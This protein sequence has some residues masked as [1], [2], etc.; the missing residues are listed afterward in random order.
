MNKYLNDVVKFISINNQEQLAIL[1][2]NYNHQQLINLERKFSDIAFIPLAVNKILP[3]DVES[4]VNYFQK[5]STNNKTNQ[6]LEIYRAECFSNWHKDVNTKPINLRDIFP[7]LYEQVFDLLPYSE[8][9]YIRFQAYR[10]PVKLHKDFDWGYNLPL[11]QRSIIF[12]SNTDPTLFVSR[13]QDSQVEYIS[14]PVDTNSFLINN[15]TC[16]NGADYKNKLLI[17][18][19]VKGI[20]NIKKLAGLLTSSSA[21]Y[22]SYSMQNQNKRYTVYNVTEKKQVNQT[23]PSLEDVLDLYK[24]LLTAPEVTAVEEHYTNDKLKSELRVIFWNKQSYENFSIRVKENYENI[25][26]KL[27][28]S[29]LD[30]EIQFFRFTSSNNYQSEFKETDYPD[31]NILLDWVFIPYFANWF[32][33]NILPLGKVQQYLGQ[34]KFQEIGIDGARY[35]KQRTSNIQRLE[36]SKQSMKDFPDLLT[37]D[38]EHALQ[39]AIGKEPFV[40]HRLT[41]LSNHVEQLAQEYIENCEHS[42]VLVGHSSLGKKINVHTHRFSDTKKYSM[43]F[44]VRLTF[45]DQPVKYFFYDPIKEIDPLF[46]RYYTNPNLLRSYVENLDPYI[47][48]TEARSSVLVFNAGYTPHSVTYSDDIYLYYVYD[49]VTLKP[50]ALEKIQNQSQKVLFESNPVEDRLFFWDL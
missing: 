6:L 48:Q 13:S 5:N 19:E 33:A 39:Y 3:Y 45:F 29:Y 11:T 26:N 46:T 20:P 37:Y 49:N 16:L 8:I 34:G 43:T 24:L 40:Y 23:G 28:N 10:Q 25:V 47:I 42:A 7:E 12:D 38:F 18:L 32:V 44:I 35:F 2:D 41:K 36:P 50:D 9:F 21:Q 14:L 30:Q 17:Y 22:G 31:A 27:Q 4:F 15:G 1:S